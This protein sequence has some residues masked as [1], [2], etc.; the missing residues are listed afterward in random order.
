MFENKN[1]IKLIATDMDGTLLNV[2]GELPH[3]FYNIVKELS[4]NGVKFVVA[5]GRQ[6]YNVRH[7]FDPIIEDV[8]I[9]A[10][11]GG[12]TF[13]DDTLIGSIPLETDWH[14]Y[15]DEVDKIP[16][17]YPVL[18]CIGKAYI[19]NLNMEFLRNVINY[20]RRIEIVPD[21]RYIDDEVI[22]VAVF[23]FKNAERNCYPYLEKFNDQALV[24]VS[25]DEWVDIN[26]KNCNKGTAL[27]NLQE[28][29]GI[30]K[31]ETMVFGD[32]LN[33]LEMMS[34]AKYSFAMKNA[35]TKLKEAANFE[36]PSNN[37][38]GVVKVIE[39]YFNIKSNEL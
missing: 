15:I 11:N 36:A 34:E 23:D 7:I 14:I 26:A 27:R 5:T 1:N 17:S 16:Y 2:K 37:E 38:E 13:S 18:S 8:I 22:K 12:V 4:K 28:D 19:K 21:F 9:I 32:F 3:N 10:D 39:E 35:H 6:Y 30:T 24:K 25:S 33:D 31:D 20:Y 29:F